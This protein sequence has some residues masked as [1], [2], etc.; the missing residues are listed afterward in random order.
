MDPK[1]NTYAVQHVGGECTKPLPNPEPEDFAD[2]RFA[3]I[4][5]VIRTWDI[6][7]PAAY[8]GYCGATGSHVKAILIALGER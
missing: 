2:P 5:D 1:T 7:V 6:N 8:H 3:R 4:W